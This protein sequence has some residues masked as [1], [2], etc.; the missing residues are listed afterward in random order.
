MHLISCS[1]IQRPGTLRL[2]VKEEEQRQEEATE[3][4]FLCFVI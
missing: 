4:T 1:K 3:N 2:S